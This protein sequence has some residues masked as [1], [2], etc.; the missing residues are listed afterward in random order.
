MVATRHKTRRRSH[1]EKSKMAQREAPYVTE[2][3]LLKTD[4]GYKCPFCPRVG[5]YPN[6]V[7][8]LQT[9]KSSVIHGEVI[10]S[11]PGAEAWFP[12][13]GIHAL[14]G[15]CCDMG[16]TQRLSEGIQKDGTYEK[17]VCKK[18]RRSIRLAS[19]KFCL[20]GDSLY[21]GDRR[22]I[23][24]E[25]EKV[26]VLTEVHAGH[27]GPRRMQEKIAPRF[28]WRGITQDTLDWVR[29]CPDCQCFEKLK[30]EAPELKPIKP[31]SPWHMVGVDLFGPMLK[32]T[33]G[34]RYCFTLTDYFTKWVEA[35]TFAKKTAANVKEDQVQSL[36]DHTY[37][38]PTQ[39]WE[40]ELHPHQVQ[41]G[42]DV[43]I[44]DMYAVPTWTVRPSSE[45]P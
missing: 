10:P 13:G 1:S 2:C 41:L 24:T 11:G 42:K 38:G 28:Y 27:F 21:Y 16:K 9:H 43:F 26:A 23:L 35:R 30:T 15:Q 31:V 32:S 3:R 22:V 36:A 5:E 25:E 7:A 20:R 4:H 14:V 19:E 17:D 29:T 12:G 44:A 40:K 33:K 45:Y 34:N 8:H 18:L 39:A 37:V 6:M